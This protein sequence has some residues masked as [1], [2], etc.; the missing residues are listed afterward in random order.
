MGVSSS[1]PWESVNVWQFDQRIRPADFGLRAFS[2]PKNVVPNV[3][4][5]LT[6][7]TA[8]GFWA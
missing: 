3:R 8:T 7:V 2:A 6:R 5:E 1:F 4:I